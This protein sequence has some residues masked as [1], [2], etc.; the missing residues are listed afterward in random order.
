M[1]HICSNGMQKRKCVAR[2][3]FLNE[4]VHA[5]SVLFLFCTSTYPHE[6]IFFSVDFFNG[7]KL[8][9]KTKNHIKMKVIVD[10]DTGNDDAWSIISLLRAEC[11]ADYRVIAITCVNG[12][13]TV[14]HSSL[15]TLLVLKTLDRLDIPVS[16]LGHDT[17]HIHS[18][19][20]FL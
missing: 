16:N 4:L 15:N 13:T 18:S 2:K 6:N 19:S 5:S 7:T 12:N 10:C 8:E 3:S 1:I 20:L 17:T 14:D 11:I 9:A